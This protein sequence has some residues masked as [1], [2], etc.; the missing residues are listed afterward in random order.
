MTDVAEVAEAS[1]D[2]DAGMIQRRTRPFQ[3]DRVQPV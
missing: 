2:R 3:H 1:H